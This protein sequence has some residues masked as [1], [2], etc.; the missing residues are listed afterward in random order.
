MRYLFF[1][2]RLLTLI[3]LM[4][5][6]SSCHEQE[7]YDFSHKEQT[8][9]SQILSE[10][11][12]YIRRQEQVIPYLIKKELRSSDFRASLARYKRTNDS[13]W[14][15]IPIIQ[16]QRDSLAT[17]DSL[18]FAPKRTVACV[19]IT[20]DC[21]YPQLCFYEESPTF[22]YH[23]ANRTNIWY[24]HFTG[25]LK[26]YNEKAHRVAILNMKDGIPA[27]TRFATAD[28]TDTKDGGTL[29][30]VEVTAP[31]KYTWGYGNIYDYF[32]YISPS[33]PG[34]DTEYG[35]GDINGPGSGTSSGKK[36]NKPTEPVNDCDDKKMEQAKRQVQDA[37]GKLLQATSFKIGSNNYVS[38]SDFQEKVRQNSNIEWNAFVRD[39][40]ADGYGVGLSEP[41]T[42]NNA[43][44]G[45]TNHLIESDSECASIHNHNNM[46]PISMVDIMELIRI[47]TEDKCS[48]FTTMIAW[49]NVN[50][51]YYC[52][53]I[54]NVDMARSF[55]N[56]FKQYIDYDTGYWQISSKGTKENPIGYFLNSQYDAI[57]NHAKGKEFFYQII[58][59][60]EKYNS[61]VSLV[62]IKTGKDAGGDLEY[63]YTSY[64]AAQVKNKKYIIIKQC[65]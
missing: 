20:K 2:T 52:A 6:L 15:Q 61:G 22:N 18:F 32:G 42:L 3:V 19:L 14:V 41:T 58:T 9:I 57:E 55:Y 36:E 46:T 65:P 10:V 50:D 31:W 4:P 12:T 7:T 1:Y 39:Y 63:Y 40:S 8:K 33:I 16:L 51:E 60:L 28:S 48:N 62:K 47:R 59:T 21:K 27:R 43:N 29:D 26:I 30:E 23:K 5:I 45:S 44:K 34:F 64:G 54:T 35:G 38:L 56:N 24:Q 49:D 11:M 13:L 17:M 37:H 25:Q 53:T